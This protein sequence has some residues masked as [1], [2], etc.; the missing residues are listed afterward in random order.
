MWYAVHLGCHAL[1]QMTKILPSPRVPE[2]TLE[3]RA[4]FDELLGDLFPSAQLIDGPL[5]RRGEAA[6][7]RRAPAVGGSMDVNGCRSMTKS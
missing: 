3:L 7:A 2:G 6:R 4:S 1:A 5:G